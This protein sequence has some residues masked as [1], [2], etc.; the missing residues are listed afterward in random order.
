MESGAN[1]QMFEFVAVEVSH[2][3]LDFLAARR[4]HTKRYGYRGV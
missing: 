4:R 3:E 2:P 1:E